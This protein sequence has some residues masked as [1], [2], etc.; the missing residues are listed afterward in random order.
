VNPTNGG[1][2][3]LLSLIIAM[4]LGVLHLP[5]SWP[6]WLGWLRPNWLLL[7]IFFWVIEVPHRTGLIAVWLIGLLVDVLYADPLG[8]NAF[9]LAAVTYIAWRF[10]ERFRMYS[11]LQ[12]CGIVFVLVLASELISVFIIGLDSERVWGWPVM[13]TPLTTMV[14]WPFVFL[15]LLRIRTGARVE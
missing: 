9:L 15:L 3:I 6:G 2:V 11:V 14:A 10:C 1:W 5:E 8:L 13:L 4:L 7:V 12:Q